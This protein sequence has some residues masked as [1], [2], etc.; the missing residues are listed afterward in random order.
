MKNKK[1]IGK[2]IVALVLLVALMLPI[3]TMFFHVFENHEHFTCIEKTEHVHELPTKCDICYFYVESP[4][5]DV[6]KFSDLL[7]LKAPV[8][9][10]LNFAPLQFHSLR[11]TNNRLRGPPFYS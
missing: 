6:A 9:V 11:I 2:R 5:Y 7:V 3:T 1:Q 8:K 4:D 10:D